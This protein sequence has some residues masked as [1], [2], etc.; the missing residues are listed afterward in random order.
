MTTVI[1]VELN[2]KN[3][4]EKENTEPNNSNTK[5]KIY[6][7]LGLLTGSSWHYSTIIKSGYAVVL[8]LLL[9][10]FIVK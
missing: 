9:T 4:V 3:V 10:A 5:K 8:L 6:K 2:K 1:L 7:K